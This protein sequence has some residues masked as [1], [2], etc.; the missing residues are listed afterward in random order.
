MIPFS[1]LSLAAAPGFADY[2][3]FLGGLSHRNDIGAGLAQT[4]AP[5]LVVL[6]FFGVAMG[7]INREDYNH[8]PLTTGLAVELQLA[9]YNRQ[10]ALALKGSVY[11]IVSVASCC[12]H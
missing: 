12:I 10:T 3:G 11:L 4:L 1:S 2:L 7:V 8:T 6:I 9:S 5:A